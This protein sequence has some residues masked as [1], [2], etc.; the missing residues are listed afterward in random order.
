MCHQKGKKRVE[1]Y[2]ILYLA[3]NVLKLELNQ[4]FKSSKDFMKIHKHT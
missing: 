1:N 2:L 3:I 4:L